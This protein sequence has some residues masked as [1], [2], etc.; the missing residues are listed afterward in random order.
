MFLAHSFRL[1]LIL[2]DN[3]LR[4]VGLSVI[5]NHEK[6]TVKELEPLV[7]GLSLPYLVSEVFL[8]LN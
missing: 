6:Y 4:G 8:H 1:V 3:V 5:G 7:S 2:V